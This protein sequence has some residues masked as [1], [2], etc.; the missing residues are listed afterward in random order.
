LRVEVQESIDLAS[1][2]TDLNLK[3]VRSEVVPSI[4]HLLNALHLLGLIV[5]LKEGELLRGSKIYVN[6]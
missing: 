5:I 1:R 4:S 3:V 2:A 6:N